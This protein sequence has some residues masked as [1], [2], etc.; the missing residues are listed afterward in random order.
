[1][2]TTITNRE[3]LRNY[4]AIKGRLLRGE[5]TSVEVDQGDGQV[6]IL[7]ISK[8]KEY[9]TAFQKMLEQ[10]EKRPIHIE[11]PTADLFDYI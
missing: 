3:L 4:K 5:L 7:K 2:T 1:M 11:R 9:K 10:V 6:I 8:K